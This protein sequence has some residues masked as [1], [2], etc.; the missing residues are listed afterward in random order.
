MSKQYEI[1]ANGT[2][3]GTYEADSEQAARD[4]AA[5]DAG[6][7]SEADMAAQLEQPSELIAREIA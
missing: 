2:I 4:L 7:K 6:Y 1:S 5:Q 3:F